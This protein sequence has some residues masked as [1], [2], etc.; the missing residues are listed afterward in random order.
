MSPITNQ[1]RKCCSLLILIWL[2]KRE[3]KER[4]FMTSSNGQAVGPTFADA[5]CQ[6][7]CECVERDQLTLRRLS[8][9]RLGV[10]PPIV[11]LSHDIP[12]SIGELHLK[13][14]NASLKLVLF[15]CTADIP[16]PVYWAILFDPNGY[17][18]FSGWGCHI[19]HEHAAERAI[20]EAIQSRAVY[21][22]GA[23]DD[24]ER[25]QV[26]GAP[27]VRCPVDDHRD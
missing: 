12:E 21:I 2:A 20:L 18:S 13:C 1:T 9:S 23:R 4:H 10:Y 15:Y 7:L 26:P 25:K 11:D 6:G 5:F 17:A 14:S 19:T 22:A 24:I 16:I 3:G 27:R 8:L